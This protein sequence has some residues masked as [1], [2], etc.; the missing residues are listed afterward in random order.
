MICYFEQKKIMKKKIFYFI[1]SCF[2]FQNS[3]SMKICKE[4]GTSF[5][6]KLRWKKI[7]LIS[8]AVGCSVLSFCMYKKGYGKISF[9]PVVCSLVGAHFFWPPTLGRMKSDD[10][11][12]LE[13]N[14]QHIEEFENFFK[15]DHNANNKQDYNHFVNCFIFF[16][17]KKEYISLDNMLSWICAA[18][19]IQ[20]LSDLDDMQN[21]LIKF[22]NELK[23]IDDAMS[24]YCKNTPKDKFT[25]ILITPE[26]FITNLLK[27][28]N[29]ISTV[30]KFV[31]ENNNYFYR[32]LY[33]YII[34][35]SQYITVKKFMKNKDL[36]TDTET[37]NIYKSL[38]IN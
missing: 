30:I 20:W 35:G 37:E 22:I 29:T 24:D 1:L 15:N 21:N 31:N 23:T 18:Q 10:H 9:A 3:Y 25:G 27:N 28:K 38:G 26:N 5:K 14:K 17:K 4:N 7:L 12:E 16:F 11:T 32:T 13:G 8:Q 6:E 34:N 19:N 2:T 36:N 33:P